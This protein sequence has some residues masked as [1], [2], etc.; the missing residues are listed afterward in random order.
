MQRPGSGPAAAAGKQRAAEGA[1]EAR[2]AHG[3]GGAAAQDGNDAP[4]KLQADG[5]KQSIKGSAANGVVS[6]GVVIGT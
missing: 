5:G 1:L 3:D 6:G 4:G 2:D